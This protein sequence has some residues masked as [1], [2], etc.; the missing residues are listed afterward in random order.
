MPCRSDQKRHGLLRDERLIY[1]VT[2]CS[3]AKGRMDLPFLDGNLGRHGRCERELA[4]PF[5][6]KAVS[7]TEALGLI[8]VRRLSGSGGC[9]FFFAMPA[10]SPRSTRLDGFWGRFKPTCQRASHADPNNQ[11]D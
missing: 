4:R 2:E 10:A 5:M 11:N 7:R 1:L 8:F 9:C 3:I 6:R